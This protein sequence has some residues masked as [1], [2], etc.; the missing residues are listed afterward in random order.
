M[1]KDKLRCP[2]WTVTTFFD[3]IG[4]YIKNLTLLLLSHTKSLRSSLLN[5]TLEDEG[6]TQASIKSKPKSWFADVPISDRQSLMLRMIETSKFRY[7]RRN[8]VAKLMKIVQH[9]SDG[10]SACV[11][12]LSVTASL[13]VL[14]SY[15]LPLENVWIMHASRT[16]NL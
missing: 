2:Q 15:H 3:D 4:R 13:L 10:V 5:F 1:E 14:R 9:E 11:K 8:S 6:T 16:K 12:E 7:L